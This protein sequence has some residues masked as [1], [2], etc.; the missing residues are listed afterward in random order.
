MPEYMRIDS[1]TFLNIAV[2][3][4][5]ALLTGS[6][7]V[8]ILSSGM[9]FRLRAVGPTLA[10][11]T[12]G[13]R[14]ATDDDLARLDDDGGGSQHRSPASPWP[15]PIAVDSVRYRPAVPYGPVEH[16]PTPMI[17][18]A[19]ETTPLTTFG[20]PPVVVEDASMTMDAATIAARQ[21]EGGGA[22]SERRPPRQGSTWT[23]L[24]KTL[25]DLLIGGH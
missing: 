5:F 3:T 13:P 12:P 19:W 4:T 21:R 9:P 8:S 20:V 18:G 24:Q 10:Y 17:P 16:F 22:P 2:L 14:G 1:T 23:R 6:L 15:V 11:G 25:R 7:I